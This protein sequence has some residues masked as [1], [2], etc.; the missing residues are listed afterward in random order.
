M[1]KID[2][3]DRNEQFS[4]EEEGFRQLNLL[5]KI[6]K[7]DNQRE[8]LI[9]KLHKLQ[10]TIKHN[11]Y[12]NFS[13]KLKALKTISD[14]I[15]QNKKTVLSQI[16]DS[17]NFFEFSDKIKKLKEFVLHL[18]KAIKRR[19]IDSNTHRITRDYYEDQLKLL[20]NNLNKVKRIAKEYIIILKNQELQLR[21]EERFMNSNI[22]K[23]IPHILNNKI[24]KKST[25]SE[26]N[27]FTEIIDF[28]SKQ[29]LKHSV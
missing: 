25:I 16:K 10:K 8:M 7:L 5:Y 21:A 18:N 1:L 6:Y 12:E 2:N 23:K 3:F 24:G 13:I 20:F 19:E 22:P 15:V 26:Q 17:Y 27:E 14:E 9:K 4:E 28:L 29:V 11:P